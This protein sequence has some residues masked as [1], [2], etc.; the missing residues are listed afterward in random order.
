MNTKLEIHTQVL[1][2]IASLLAFLVGGE[3]GVD[4]VIGSPGP[5]SYWGKN[6]L[7]QNGCFTTSFLILKT[8]LDPRIVNC[9]P[10]KLDFY[11]S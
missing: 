2:A 6:V 3:I 8:H 7:M 4:F 1:T 10:G 5:V 9:L 11:G